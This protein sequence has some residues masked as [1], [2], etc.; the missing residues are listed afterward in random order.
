M[1]EPEDNPRAQEGW[2]L[3]IEGGQHEAERLQLIG[4][5]GRVRRARSR[6]RLG[7]RRLGLMELAPGL[8][9]PLAGL[10]H[11]GPRRPQAGRRLGSQGNVGS[12]DAQ[13]GL[14]DRRALGEARAGA[15]RLARPGRQFQR[16][17]RQQGPQLGRHDVQPTR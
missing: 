2:V 9:R 10:G 17:R 6:E 1:R 13:G 11:I 5:T 14:P 3:G 8:D 15:D 7:E 12:Q 4:G 16:Q